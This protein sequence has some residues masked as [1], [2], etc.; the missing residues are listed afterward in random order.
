MRPVQFTNFTQED[1]I[2][3]F[4]G[5][6]W[7][8]PAG[9]SI[10]L[11]SEKACHFA[12]HLVDRELHKIG[13][14][15]SDMLQHEIIKKI[16]SDLKFDPLRKHQVILDSTGSIEPVIPGADPLTTALNQASERAGVAETPLHDMTR[17][18]LE[19]KAKTI[20]IQ[21][22]ELKKARNKSEIIKM[23][24]EG[25]AQTDGKPKDDEFAGL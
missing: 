11:E 6:A 15:V 12:K 9:K 13:K 8:F 17:S 7:T 21:P 25:P 23:I 1:F 22:E 5:Q 3:K 14:Q 18:E 16:S 24:E 4:N 19:E 10:M 20:G 2:A